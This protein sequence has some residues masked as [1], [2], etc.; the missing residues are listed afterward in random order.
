M[1]F[2][3]QNFKSEDKYLKPLKVS[4]IMYVLFFFNKKKLKSLKNLF[5][6]IFGS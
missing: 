3:L 5:E 1:G 6:I 2:F 4:L